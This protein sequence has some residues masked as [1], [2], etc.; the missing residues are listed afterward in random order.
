LELTG[1][2]NSINAIRDHYRQAPAR[3]L[4]DEG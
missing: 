4:L 3:Y 1:F 2:S